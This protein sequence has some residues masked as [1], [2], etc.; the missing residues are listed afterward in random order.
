MRVFLPALA[1]FA[2]AAAPCAAEDYY[3]DMATAKH[4]N[5]YVPATIVAGWIR[6]TS[7]Q[8]L[9]IAPDG[10]RLTD[11]SV[12]KDWKATLLVAP[13]AAPKE[14]DDYD[15]PRYLDRKATEPKRDPEEEA[16]LK[17]PPVVRREVVYSSLT[18]PALAAQMAALKPLTGFEYDPPKLTG[19]RDGPNGDGHQGFDL[20]V[21]IGDGE[22][23]KSAS[24]P[25]SR[26]G[27][28][29]QQT[30]AALAAC[31]A[32]LKPGP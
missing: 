32:A 11:T 20:W 15:D 21:R 30:T 23:T 9:S 1:L 16:A 25:D 19:N 26:L 6:L 24:L 5:G 13:K 18:C 12:A 31:P 7:F 10:D 14:D 27:Q 8:V 22:L 2:L 28:W 4:G 3:G 29:F 17:A